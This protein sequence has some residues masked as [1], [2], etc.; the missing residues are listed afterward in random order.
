MQQRSANWMRLAAI[1]ALTGGY[2][3][4][5]S[6]ED[7]PAAAP[8]PAAEPAPA[9]AAEAATAAPAPA[10]EAPS[11]PK[12][13]GYV[14][15]SYTYD[16][17]NPLNNVTTYRVYDVHN[18]FLLN[19]AHVALTGS[20][21]KVGYAI[22]TDMGHDAFVHKSAGFGVTAHVPTLSQ[23]DPG[24]ATCLTAGSQDISVDPDADIF[25]VQE[26]YATFPDPFLALVG[27]DATVKVGKWATYSGIELIESGSNPTITRG[28]L[29][30]WAEAWT[31]VGAAV[32]VPVGP[33]TVTVGVING[34]DKIMDNNDAQTG[35]LN[36]FANLGDAIGTVN[37]TGYSGSE[38]ANTG[39]KKN[40]VDVTGVLKMIPMVDL[41]W[42]AT[43]N[44][45]QVYYDPTTMTGGGV[46]KNGGATLQPL[47]KLNDKFTVGLRAEY[48][49]EKAYAAPGNIWSNGTICLNWMHAAG[50]VTRFEFR[51]DESKNVAG[52]A[53]GGAA[54][55]FE[56]W[57][58]DV[59]GSGIGKMKR[60]ASTISFE[61]IVS[62]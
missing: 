57:E 58:E 47:I 33:A 10:A 17:N 29:F 53:N 51:H 19:N 30:G 23:D 40:H 9:P 52:T 56:S 15:S 43:Y 34:W 31:H 59:A 22:E 14:Q 41:W 25:D 21:G 48:F 26:A 62:F 6:A 44:D 39:L 18:S 7:A 16:M 32:S 60:G 54:G 28:Y 24:C 42:Q 50:I 1:L 27:I 61:T 2:A 4:V 36:I 46:N 12:I 45:Q 20:I 35:L 11:G 38:D 37:I 49:E 5:A 3:V 55:R 8:A 13:S